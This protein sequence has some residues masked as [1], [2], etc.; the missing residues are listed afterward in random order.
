LLAAN[1]TAPRSTLLQ[2]HAHPHVATSFDARALTSRTPPVAFLSSSPSRSPASCFQNGRSLRTA[3]HPKEL[4]S[5][6]L[7]A[8]FQQCGL[9]Q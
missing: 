5:V 2:S 1:C 3:L 8:T 4:I 9:Q 7:P 6:P